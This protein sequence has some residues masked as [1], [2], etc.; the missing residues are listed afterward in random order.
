MCAHAA[1][2]GVLEAD[3]ASTGP[4]ATE[5]V[6]PKAACKGSQGYKT[7]SCFGQIPDVS[8]PSQ[9]TRR[10]ELAVGDGAGAGTGSPTAQVQASSCLGLGASPGGTAG[11]V[12]VCGLTVPRPDRVTGAEGPGS[13]WGGGLQS[14]GL[15]HERRYSR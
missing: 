1:R 2:W 15:A 3:A 14:R 7:R 12:C 8:V 6:I 4:S 5:P 11:C 9:L 10:E 13:V